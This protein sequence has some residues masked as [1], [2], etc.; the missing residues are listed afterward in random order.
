MKLVL[1]EYKC[2]Y[3]EA[4]F[5]APQ[6]SPHAYGEFLLRKKTSSSLRYLDAIASSVY[7]DVADELQIN[8][9]TS[10]LSEL[11][12]SDILQVIFGP[13]A[14]DPDSDGEPFEMGLLPYCPNCKERSSLSWKIT[15]P[16]EFVEIDVPSVQFF[17]WQ[18]LTAKEKKM[19][20]EQALQKFLKSL[21]VA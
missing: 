12:R 8:P 10:G 18:R 11:T 17:V 14:C 13:V 15:D 19:K 20:I 21:K 7:S 2:K 3:C 16:I 5:K 1:F 4:I 6:I 9:E